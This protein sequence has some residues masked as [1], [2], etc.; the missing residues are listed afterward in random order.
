MI[1]MKKIRMKNKKIFWALI[2]VVLVLL[3]SVGA[4]GIYA[5]FYYHADASVESA[6][7]SYGEVEVK[8]LSVGL[9]FLP[10]RD[11]ANGLIFYPGAKVEYI[12]YAPLMR[13]L[14][15]Q[16]VLCV[17]VDMPCNLALLDLDAAKDVPAQFPA[18]QNWYLGGHSLGGVCASIYLENA[19]GYRGLILLASY[20]D[21]DL[22]S[23]P[24]SV[25]SIYGSEDGVLNREQYARKAS[26]S[27][28]DRKEV[29][30]EGG[31]HAGFG[32]YGVQKGDGT[33]TIDTAQQIA[34]TVREIV[35]FLAER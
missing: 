26:N 13:S 19:D 14:A 24:L 27:P 6:C 7:Q 31:C 30:L 11:T 4:F 3:L 9:A 34:E 29:I 12:A 5:G 20:I 17:L 16:G 28:A 21:R 2:A 32:Y 22:S 8:T 33:P 25:L 10:E 1:G 18:V 35:A 15:E 23:K